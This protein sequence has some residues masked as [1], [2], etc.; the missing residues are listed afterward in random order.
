MAGTRLGHAHI[1]VRDV[2]RSKKFYSQILGLE[3]TE[4]EPG[5][6]A[7]LSSGEAHHELALSQVGADAPGP[8]AGGVGLFHLGFDAADAKD[9]ARIFRR[10]LEHEIEIDPVDHRISWGVYFSDPDGNRLELCLDTREEPDGS[11]VWEGKNRPLTRERI[12]A[13]LEPSAPAATGG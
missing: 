6:W 2:E 13:A 11:D 1:F 5:R 4:S 7:F 8:V 9:F 10:L 12:M 3:I